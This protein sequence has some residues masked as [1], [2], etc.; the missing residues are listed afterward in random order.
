[1]SLADDKQL[2]VW[3]K[4]MDLAEAI[5][6]PIEHVYSRRRPQRLS[7]PSPMKFREC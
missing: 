4:A 7:L 3:A 5:Y 2:D 1:M 6:K